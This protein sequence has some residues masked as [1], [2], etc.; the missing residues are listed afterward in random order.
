MKKTVS[1]KLIW[2]CIVGFV[3]IISI[4]LFKNLSNKNLNSN[5]EKSKYLY[6]IKNKY[7]GDSSADMKI[8]DELKIAKD[9]NI[10]IKTNAEGNNI[11]IINVN[12]DKIGNLSYEEYSAILLALIE[13][14]SEVH[15]NIN[16]TEHIEVTVDSIARKY[17]NIKDYAKT[18]EELHSFLTSLGYYKEREN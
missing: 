13:N 11:L 1:K 4:A 5:E 16:N 18:P 15:W 10:E 7:I 6:S 2:I 9:L 17:A 12:G 3:A 14:A 8:I